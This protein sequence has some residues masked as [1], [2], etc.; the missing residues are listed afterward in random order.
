MLSEGLHEK[1]TELVIKVLS[2][3][4]AQSVQILGIAD[5]EQE[6]DIGLSLLVWAQEEANIED[7]LLER[8]LNRVSRVT[9]IVEVSLDNKVVVSHCPDSVERTNI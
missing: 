5:C 7:G 4:Q 8:P 3:C 6:V 9:Q 1:E 2:R